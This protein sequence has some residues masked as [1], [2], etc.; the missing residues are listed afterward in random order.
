MTIR[1][2]SIEDDSRYRSSLEALFR[3]SPGLEVAGSY[4]SPAAALADLEE[5]GDAVGWD[6]VVMDIDLPEMSG[7]EATRR[8]KRRLPDVPIMVLTVFEDAPT[9]LEAIC[10]GA[11]GYLTKDTA[12]AELLRQLRALVGGGSPLTS[13]VASTVLDLLRHL[14]PGA[15][16]GPVTPDDDGVL[17]LT[18]R[19]REVLRCLV[20][21][22]QYKQIARHLDISIDTVRT[23]I[24]HVYRK[25]QVRN[26]AEAVTRAL[27]ERLV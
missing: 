17:A 5:A 25:L 19:E 24:R 23:H 11:D 26:A 9:I 4:G 10:A 21:G 15:D 16:A 2:A 8:I 18:D 22:M 14:G 3:L 7:I 6:V 20:S 1:V 13:G 12:P 27:R